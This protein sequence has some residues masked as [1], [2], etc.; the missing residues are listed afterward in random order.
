MWEHSHINLIY[1]EVCKTNV[2]VNVTC[3]FVHICVFISVHQA[4]P[5]GDPSFQ[6]LSDPHVE[7]FLIHH[8]LLRR[9]P[10]LCCIS[11]P[12]SGSQNRALSLLPSGT[13]THTPHLIIQPQL[14]IRVAKPLLSPV[15]SIGDSGTLAVEQ[16]S[17][18]HDGADE[19]SEHGSKK[20]NEA[21]VASSSED[22]SA[23]DDGGE[24]SGTKVTGWVDGLRRV[25]SAR[26]LWLDSQP[27]PPP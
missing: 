27:L 7:A 8:L 23:V 19:A 5:F 3:Y 16:E 9:A 12:H 2:S 10:C 15:N 13:H 1:L 14:A 25:K 26:C 17:I 4:S 18:V 24:E 6:T 22:L 20:R 21:V 11:L